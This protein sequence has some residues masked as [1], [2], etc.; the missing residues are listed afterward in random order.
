[1]VS[2]VGVPDLGAVSL[3]SSE[4]QLSVLEGLLRAAAAGRTSALMVSAVVS[5]VRAAGQVLADR[6]D[7][8]IAALQA[9]L[10]QLLA[11]RVIPAR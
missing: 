10:D 4:E 7:D 5:I 9:Q 6:R 1:M 2:L 3:K 11:D 8:Q